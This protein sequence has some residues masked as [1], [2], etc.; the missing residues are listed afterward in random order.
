MRRT[1]ANFSS[2]AMKR[3][4]LREKMAILARAFW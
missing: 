3:P 4:S 1:A 2:F